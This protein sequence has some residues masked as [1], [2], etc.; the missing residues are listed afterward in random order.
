[1]VICSIP[2]S[3]GAYFWLEEHLKLPKDL[4]KNEFH[5]V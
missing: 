4:E 2:D 1:M 3:E 5:G